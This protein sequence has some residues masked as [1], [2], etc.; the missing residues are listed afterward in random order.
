MPAILVAG[1]RR[2]YRARKRQEHTMITR[3]KFMG[4]PVRDQKAQLA[5]YTE[6]LGFEVL[7][8]QPL[9]KQRWIELKIP[10]A[11]THVV[12]FTPEGHEDRVGTFVNASLACDDVKKTYEELKAR[13]VEFTQP[14]TEQ[15]WGTF[16]KFKDADGNQFVLSSR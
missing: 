15:P 6:K 8:D 9:G 5:F 10:R 7:T 12:L 2:A 4:I 14:P 16:A 3:V 1:A 13:G 11:E